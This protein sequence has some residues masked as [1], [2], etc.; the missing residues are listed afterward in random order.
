MK[1]EL[2]AERETLLIPL[3]SKAAG[4]NARVPI[5]DDPKAAEILAALDYDFAA[6][7][8]PAGTA[9]TLCVRAK[10]LDAQVEQLC[11]RSAETTVLHLGCGL[12][13]RAGR[14]GRVGTDWYDLDLPEVI[15]L[16]RRFYEESAGYHM[17]ASSVTELAWL[18]QIPASR[19]PTVIVAEGLFMYLDEDQV[20]A[21]VRALR[22]RFPGGVLAFDAYSTLTVRKVKNHPS[23]KRT[24]AKVR[25][26]VDDPRELEAWAP[27]LSLLQEWCFSES[28][29]VGRWGPWFWVMFKLAGLFSVARR[30]HRILIYQL[31]AQT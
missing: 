2:E 24:G 10:Q 17:I 25:W 31:G 19:R 6:L 13:D 23:I 14:V 30:A 22:E 4:R 20:K 21:L 15:A 9:V 11:A 26:G 1:V 18:D 3:L 27:G 28:P 7:R 29:D 5:L 16:R 8:V 12:D